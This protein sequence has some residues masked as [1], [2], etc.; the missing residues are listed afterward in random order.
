MYTITPSY[1]NHSFSPKQQV[2]T[3]SSQ[4]PNYSK[5]DFKD[6]SS[7]TIDGYVFYENSTIPV[8]DATFEIG[9]SP[10]T[11]NG[12][13]IRSDDKGYFKFSV[14]AGEQTVRVLKDNHTFANKG[15]LQNDNGL[16]FNYQTSMSLALDGKSV[17]K[18]NAS[19]IAVTDEMN[20]TLA[21]WFKADAGQTNAALVSNGIAN[22]SDFNSSYNKI[23]I[24]FKNGKLI[25][26][27][28]KLEKEV[29]GSYLD[30]NWHHFAIAVNRNAG[31]AQIFIDGGLKTYFDASTLGGI[32]AASLNLGAC[33]WID[34]STSKES[35]DSYLKGQI[36]ELQLWNM[37]PTMS[38]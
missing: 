22:G 29:D 8:K 15:L 34:S 23:F 2:A 33:N 37:I 6:I 30:N 19:R 28:N 35:T 27:N 36:D 1:E 5:A 20:Y 17:A 7:F 13:Y 24:G 3:I 11:S 10:V 4:Q 18:V 26:R 12:D 38:I 21:F 9:G 14:P 32:S 25:F 16:N 31:N